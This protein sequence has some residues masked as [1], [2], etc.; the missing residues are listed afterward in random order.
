MAQLILIYQ[1]KMDLF[2]EAIQIVFVSCFFREH[3]IYI[4]LC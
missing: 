3:Y 2:P 4:L 1:H